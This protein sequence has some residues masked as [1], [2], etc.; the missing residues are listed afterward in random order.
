MLVET[1]NL[2][3]ADSFRSDFDR[4]VD[5]ARS[6]S[7]PVAIT[8]DSEVIGVFISPD[9]YEALFGSTVKK[10]LKS[11]ERGPIVSHV[12]VRKQAE[13]TIRRRKA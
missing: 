2:V 3:S 1:N 11:R 7:G 12:A 9:E 10:L 5:A 8:R 6:G 13:Q 4:Y